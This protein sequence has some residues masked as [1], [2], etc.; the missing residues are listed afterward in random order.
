MRSLCK[1][2]KRLALKGDNRD[3]RIRQLSDILKQVK[4]LSNQIRAACDFGVKREDL[5]DLPPEMRKVISPEIE[6]VSEELNNVTRFFEGYSATHEAIAILEKNRGDQD[7]I[8]YIA[9]SNV[10]FSHLTKKQQKKALKRLQKRLENIIPKA[11]E[12]TYGEFKPDVEIKES[13]VCSGLGMFAKKD[14]IIGDVIGLFLGKLMTEEEAAY[15]YGPATRKRARAKYI[16]SFLA[17]GET[18][19]I[20]PYNYSSRVNH[21]GELG[22]SQPVETENMAWVELIHKNGIPYVAEVVIRNIKCGDEILTNY[23]E[24]YR[25]D[26]FSLYPETHPSALKNKSA[27]VYIQSHLVDLTT[28]ESKAPIVDLTL[29]A[30]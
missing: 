17:G 9:N 2:A 19:V 21:A 3:D 18:L 27:K 30:E 13:T 12:V 24:S 20:D 5:S 8:T 7:E 16:Y 28:P 23:G 6:I 1:K 4:E 25:E 11:L 15:Y 22:N 14:F 10:I 29:S 26:P